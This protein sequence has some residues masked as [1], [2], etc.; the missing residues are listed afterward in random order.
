MY[1]EH[2]DEFDEHDVAKSGNGVTTRWKTKWEKLSCYCICKGVL[3]NTSCE[4][5]ILFIARNEVT[6]EKRERELAEGGRQSQMMPAGFKLVDDVAK[7]QEEGLRFSIERSVKAHDST[8][9][10][11]G[12]IVRK[13]DCTCAIDFGMRSGRS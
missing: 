9:C 7:V 4:T 12:S 5:R 11:N 3:E 13:M 2:E 8:R 6:S 10:L 1:I